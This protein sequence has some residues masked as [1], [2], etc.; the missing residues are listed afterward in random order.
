M[1][2]EQVGGDAHSIVDLASTLELT[3][4]NRCCVHD[5]AD[6]EGRPV[7]CLE[8]PHWKRRVRLELWYGQQPATLGERIARYTQACSDG[9]AA[10]PHAWYTKY[11]RGANAVAEDVTDSS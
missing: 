1:Q 3:Y 8:S 6:V 11:F 10:S 2:Q 7:K 5:S 9:K 4:A